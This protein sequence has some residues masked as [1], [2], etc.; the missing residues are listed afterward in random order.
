ME[1]CEIIDLACDVCLKIKDDLNEYVYLPQKGQLSIRWE[2]SREFYAYAS[3]KTIAGEA[4]DYYVHI[5]YGVLIDLYR[6]VDQ[7]H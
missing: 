6:C 4:P 1:D 2:D 5:S 7:C 3:S